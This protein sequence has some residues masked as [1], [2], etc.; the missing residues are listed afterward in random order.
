MVDYGEYNLLFGS[1]GIRKYW[2]NGGCQKLW[3]WR[4]IYYLL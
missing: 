4:R 2:H 1:Q 3:C